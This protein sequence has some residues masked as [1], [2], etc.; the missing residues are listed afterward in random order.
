MFH[1][2]LPATFACIK[3]GHVKVKNSNSPVDI[4]GHIFWADITV[5][6]TSAVNILKDLNEQPPTELCSK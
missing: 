3:D 2:L 4:D 6:N 1:F 5:A